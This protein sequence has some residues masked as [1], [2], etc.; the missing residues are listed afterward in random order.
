M[1]EPR[2]SLSLLPFQKKSSLRSDFFFKGSKQRLLLGSCIGPLHTHL[3]G[4]TQPHAYQLSKIYK[5]ILV[6]FET[7]HFLS[8]QSIVLKLELTPTPLLTE[9]SNTLP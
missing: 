2:K 1:Q 4:P 9:Y 6:L 8:S 5:A 7:L 3:V